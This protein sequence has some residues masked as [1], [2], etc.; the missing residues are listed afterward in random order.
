MDFKLA[1]TDA[2]MTAIQMDTKL[3]GLGVAKLQ[4]MLDR[5][6]AG[7]TDILAFMKETIAAPAETISAYAPFLL[8]FKVQPEQVREIIGKG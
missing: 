8:K 5:A 7:R 3:Q 4:E 6:Q 1:G 2:G